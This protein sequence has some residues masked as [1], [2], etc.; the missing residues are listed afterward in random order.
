MK[1][2]NK[3]VLAGNLTKDVELRTTQNGT[4]VAS[5]T[6]AINSK[7]GDTERTDF[8][9]CVA[10]SKVAELINQFVTKGNPLLVEGRLQNRSWEQD[11]QKRSKVEVVVSDF[12]LLSQREGKSEG[13]QTEEL[14][15]LSDIPF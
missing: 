4:S 7:Y 10:W 2:F 9:D 15:D 14:V 12:V 1:G 5:F 3:S 13:N 11:G 6:L 8:I